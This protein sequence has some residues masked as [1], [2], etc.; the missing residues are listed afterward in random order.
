MWFLVDW[1][2]YNQDIEG[3]FESKRQK[4]FL[5]G[6]RGSGRGFLSGLK[7]GKTLRV[8]LRFREKRRSS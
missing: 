8:W 2:K 5:K 3:T 7:R 6:L 4:N 1:G